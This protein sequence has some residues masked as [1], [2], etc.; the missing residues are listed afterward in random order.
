M[1]YLR[2]AVCRYSL[3][4]SL[5][6]LQGQLLGIIRQSGEKRAA[7][8]PVSEV[9]EARLTGPNFQITGQTHE[10]QPVTRQGNTE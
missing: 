2:S 1:V 6:Q 8:I 10:E 3:I 5:T 4:L 9:M 7:E